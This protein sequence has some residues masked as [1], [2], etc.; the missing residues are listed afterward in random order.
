[1]LTTRTFGHAVVPSA[2]SAMAHAAHTQVVDST[3][4]QRPVH[5]ATVS[6]GITVTNKAIS[7]I[8]TFTLGKPAA[9]FDFAVRKGAVS[10]EPQFRVGLNGKP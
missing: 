1:M 3:A 5:R 9:I 10:F 7:L 2:F 6:G 8:P 4:A